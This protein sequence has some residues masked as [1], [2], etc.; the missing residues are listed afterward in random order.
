MKGQ[1]TYYMES[2]QFLMHKH[3]NTFY[4]SH[5]TKKEPPALNKRPATMQPVVT[6]P[7]D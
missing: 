1:P 4:G 7:S 6:P 5:I 2:M 3:I